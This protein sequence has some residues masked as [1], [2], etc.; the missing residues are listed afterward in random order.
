MRSRTRWAPFASGW[1]L[2]LLGCGGGASSPAPQPTPPAEA[3]QAYTEGA[4]LVQQ[5]RLA[6]AAAK[7]D[8]A[9]RA[10]PGVAQL[11]LAAARAHSANS[12]HELAL[13]RARTAEKLAPDD[14][15]T[16]EVFASILVRAGQLDALRQRL[17]ERV[18]ARPRDAYAW[19]ALGERHAEDGEWDES[20]QA[21]ERATT[22]D[23]GD[24]TRWEKLGRARMR[25]G[26]P[27]Q[28][29][30]AFE[31][32]RLIDPTR[33]FLDS[34]IVRLSIEAGDPPR[35]L[36]AIR[37]LSGPAST[38]SQ[39]ALALAGML[40]ERQDPVGAAT[41][42]EN[43]LTEAPADTALRLGLGRVFFA[44]ERW[45]DVES[46]LSPIPVGAP[47][48]VESMQLRAA[49]A[50]RADDQAG[51]DAAFTL[52]ETLRVEAPEA[53]RPSIALQQVRIRREQKRYDDARRV[54]DEARKQWPLDDGLQFL[55]GML[56]DDQGRRELALKTMLGL[57]ERSPRHAGALN[58]VGYTWADR[59]TRLEEAETY[60]RRALEV[61]PNDGAIVD[62]LG[63]VLF[64]RG[65][66]GSA[67]AT[68]RRAVELMPE[69]GELHY[70]LA[71]VLAA[72]RRVEESLEAFDK[73]LSFEKSP[74]LQ[75]RWK[76]R[77]AEVARG[78]GRR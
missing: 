2:W 51:L 65:D 18:A 39:A 54:I 35:A 15:D 68:L 1:A 10:D 40:T 13:E 30:D 77:R 41:V 33:R 28:A 62:S 49:A 71:E 11:W 55:D 38:P 27:L 69:E 74:E 47:E 4:V 6:E 8:L 45:A 7:F 17:R 53:D 70:H 31:R 42:L 23:A 32:A 56:H 43:A 16:A 26:K 66:L 73:A 48:R 20:E 36:A 14:A 5:G 21:F 59:G 44:S 46:T 12:A 52:L 22:L 25:A 67:E 76:K 57:V 61:E 19:T 63:W 75:A 64:R 78:R 50:L 72:G 60:I 9:A 29:A 58:Y 34:L 24:A 37:R 3:V